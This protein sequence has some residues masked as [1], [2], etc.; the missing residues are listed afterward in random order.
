G[1]KI[2][3]SLFLDG[4]TGDI[5]CVEDENGVTVDYTY[6]SLGRETGSVREASQDGEISETTIYSPAVNEKTITSSTNKFSE[7]YTYDGLGNIVKEEISFM[8]GDGKKLLI[9]REMAATQYN[10][11]GQQIKNTLYDYLLEERSGAILKKYVK[12]V[13]CEW[14]I[15][16]EIVKEIHADNSVD[17]YQYDMAVTDAFRRTLAVD[18]DPGS[19]RKTSFYDKY[20]LL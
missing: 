14:N 7:I 10:N 1:Q 13:S 8:V 6:D 11:L 4:V 20:G 12:E 2:S 17:R 9:R 15:Y 16:D 3:S 19:V 5:V 18:H